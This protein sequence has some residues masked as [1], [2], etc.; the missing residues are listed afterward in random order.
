MHVYT[1]HPFPGPLGEPLTGYQNVTD[2]SGKVVQLKRT[3][4]SGVKVTWD[5]SAGAGNVTWG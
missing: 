5:L 2:E 1:C 3:F 4:A